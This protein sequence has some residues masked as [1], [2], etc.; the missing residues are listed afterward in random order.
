MYIIQYLLWIVHDIELYV[1]VIDCELTVAIIHSSPRH[2]FTHITSGRYFRLFTTLT[3]SKVAKVLLWYIN[4]LLLKI[5]S[6]WPVE[7]WLA[8]ILWSFPKE[9]TI[10]SYIHRHPEVPLYYYFIDV[11]QETYQGYRG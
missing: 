3:I 2:H 5:T 10:T 11:L 9:L 1:D 4:F 6:Y 8:T 7:I